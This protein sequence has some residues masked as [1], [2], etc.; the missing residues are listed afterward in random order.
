[1][2]MIAE[3]TEYT[4]EGHESIDVV[5]IIVD[6]LIVQVSHELFKERPAIQPRPSHMRL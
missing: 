4:H 3:P 6:H 5:V 1:M 2:N